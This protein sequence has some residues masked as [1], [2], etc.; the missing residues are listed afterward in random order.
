MLSRRSRSTIASV[1][2]L[3]T[4]HLSLSRQTPS[5]S[6][7]FLTRSFGTKLAEIELD[8]TLARLSS[9]DRQ[10]LARLLYMTS[11]VLWPSER[12]QKKAGRKLIEN[13]SFSAM[14]DIDGKSGS[15]GPFSLKYSIIDI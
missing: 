9:Y 3:F 15:D 2:D 8:E 5:R 6:D 10:L 4:S 13:I 7:R 14:N 12:R 11:R 1:D